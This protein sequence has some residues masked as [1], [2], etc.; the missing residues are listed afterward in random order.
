[1]RRSRGPWTLAGRMEGELIRSGLY[2]EV[3]S[4]RLQDG[5]C[6]PTN[7]LGNDH[8]KAETQVMWLLSPRRLH[9]S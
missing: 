8:E 7:I 2:F 5:A 9:S 1:M 3:P 4:K 6:Q